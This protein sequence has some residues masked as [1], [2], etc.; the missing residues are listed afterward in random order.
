M[1][2]TSA[3]AYRRLV[4]VATLAAIA[5]TFACRPAWS[6]NSS[7]IVFPGKVGQNM[8]LARYDLAKQT[9]EIIHINQI[10]QEFVVPHY[11]PNGDLLLLSMKEGSKK[12]LRVRRIPFS[13]PAGTKPV[14]PFEIETENNALD[15]LILPPVIVDGALFLGGKSL[16]RV[17][18]TT[19]AIVR[20]D[21]PNTPVDLFLARRGGGICYIT[22]RDAKRKASWEFGTIDPKN[23]TGKMLFESPKVAKGKP[24]WKPLPMPCFTKDLSRMAI[25]AERVDRE[26]TD[27]TATAILVFANGKLENVLPFD[28]LNGLVSISSLA[29]AK[30]NVGLFSVIVREVD[31]GHRFSLYETLFSGSVSRETELIT[32]PASKEGT[33]PALQMQLAM[34]PDGKWAATT[35]AYVA[36]LSAQKQSLLLIDVSGKERKVQRIDFPK[37]E[38]PK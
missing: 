32:L 29:W 31:E 11:L 30:D 24:G 14:G 6:P 34:S 2:P 23:L 5:W 3:S 27:Q 7:Q 17:D 22:Q 1:S 12:T 25:P 8:A 10:E 38:A 4:T 21:L 9:S 18:L 35:S 37:Q 26:N 20:D 33:T 36:G 13:A 15:H 19:G 16:T 28:D